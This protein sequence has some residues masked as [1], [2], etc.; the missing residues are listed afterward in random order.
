MIGAH[1]RH[2]GLLC[3]SYEVESF[4]HPWMSPHRQHLILLRFGGAMSVC[5]SQKYEAYGAGV[6]MYFGDNLQAAASAADLSDSKCS[7]NR[8]IQ[9]SGATKVG[10]T[11]FWWLWRFSGVH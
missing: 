6:L 3:L 2:S 10:E 11:R 8:G 7:L 4:P 9:G 1:S 5:L